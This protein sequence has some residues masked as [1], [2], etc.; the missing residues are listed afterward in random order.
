MRLSGNMLGDMADRK[1]FE[2][3]FRSGWHG[4]YD[5]QLL[6]IYYLYTFFIFKDVIVL[7]GL[8]RDSWVKVGNMEGGEWRLHRV[9][10]LLLF[11]S[12]V[13]S[14]SILTFYYTFSVT[15]MSS[16]VTKEEKFH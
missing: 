3:I 16:V 9:S 4:E 13:Q 2:N 8:Q 11:V 14:I 5:V 12:Y 10:Q 15:S 6:V 1:C 7:S